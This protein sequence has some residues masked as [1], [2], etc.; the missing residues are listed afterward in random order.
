MSDTKKALVIGNSDGIG[1]GLTGRLLREGWAVTGLSRSAVEFDAGDYEHV[2]CDVTDA[3][4]EEHLVD[5]W[6]RRG[7]YDLV[8]HCVG[9]G[10][11]LS[12]NGFTRE[13]RTVTT[14]FTSLAQIVESL[15]P[16]M[17]ERGA[18][19]LIGLS[20][21]ADDLHIADSPSYSATKAGYSNYLR[22]LALNLRK[23]KLAVTNV[24]FGFVDTKMA[25]SDVKPRMIPVTRAVDLLMGCVRTRPVQ[26]SYP[27]SMGL[28]LRVLRWGQNLRL[29]TKRQ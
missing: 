2:V 22:S 8:V 17:L 26:L 23:T 27:K 13:T 4:Y 5:L 19:H 20:S 1:R 28:L 7:P 25:K 9:V 6:A 18:G 24:R 3:A 14:N 11:G 12:E 21:L 15:L 10:S 29:W 16:R